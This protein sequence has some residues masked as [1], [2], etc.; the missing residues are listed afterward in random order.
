MI[1]LPEAIVL[2]DQ[3]NQTIAGKRIARVVAQASPHKFAWF[4]GDPAGYDLLLRG[5]KIEKAQS[6]GG[7]IEIAAQGA[8]IDFHDGV[9]LRYYAPDKPVPEKHQLLIVFEDG[10]AL[11]ATVA[12]YGALMCYP[13]GTEEVENFYYQA[14]HRAVSPLSDAF[15]IDYFLALDGG[16]NGKL[17]AKAFLATEQRIPGLGNGVLQDILF[18]AG[19]HPRKSINTCTEG[20]KRRLYDS[21]K[22]T[23]AEMTAQGGR[24]TER[25]LFGAPGGYRTKLSKNTL[26]YPCRVCGGGLKKEAYLGGSVYVCEQCQQR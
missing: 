5:R 6:F 13:A 23:L 18:N 8:V 26:P 10:A 12:M 4:Y 3:I 11:V 9:N 24:D 22:A 21:V 16:K 17:S 14:A 15:D 7:R 20:Q 1:E 25:D 2:S 19:I